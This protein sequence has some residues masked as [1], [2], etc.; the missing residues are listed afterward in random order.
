MVKVLKMQ[1]IKRNNDFVNVIKSGLTDLKDD[2]KKIPE[3]EKR[4]EQP[5]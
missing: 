3:N 5:V 1:T 2:I 4:I